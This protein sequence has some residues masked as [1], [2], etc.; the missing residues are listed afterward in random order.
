M[1]G[2]E[3]PSLRDHKYIN[4]KIESQIQNSTYNRFKTLYVNHRKFLNKLKPSINLLLEEIRN[5]QTQDGIN[6]TT[7]HLQ[8]KVIDA[9]KNTYKIK[10]Q[11]VA[12]PPSWYTSKLEIEKNRL[13]ELRRRAQRTPKEQ[14]R[15]RFMTLKKDEALYTRHVKQAKNSGWKPSCTNA[16]NP[17]DKQYKAAFQ[18]PFPSHLIALKIN[19]PTGGQL[20]IADNILEQTFPYPLDYALLPTIRTNTPDDAPFT[21]EEIAIVNKNLHKETWPENTAI[22]AFGDHT[23]IQVVSHANTK[24]KTENQIHAAIEKFINWA[25]K[26]KL[27]ISTRK[28]QY[29]L[30]IKLTRPPR[31]RCQ[32]ET[33][34]RKHTIK[35]LGFLIDD[36]LNWNEHLRNLSTK[37]FTLC[38]NLLKIT[39]ENLESSL[40]LRRMLYKTVIERMLAYGAA[41]WCLDPPVRIKR[42]LNTIQRPFLL[43]L[44]GANRTTA[45]SALQVIL[46]I[47]PLNLQLQ[48]EARV[49]A[50]RRLKTPFRTL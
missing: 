38:Q 48:Q 21:K 34:Q 41:V 12:R 29:I 14:R 32:E 24:I 23:A 44:T 26:N 10:K 37:S 25:N 11:E 28:T 5:S 7:S 46:G 13:K 22:Q 3:E 33:I 18:K 39:G 40:K 6:K 50:I 35:Y 19:N 1:G 36:K 42:K 30:F 49:T 31:I 20:K 43:A 16:S 4:V 45:T 27:Q 15:R 47:P 17:Y 9:C 8:N 2:S